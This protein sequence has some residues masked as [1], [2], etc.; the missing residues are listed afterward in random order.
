MSHRL[1]LRADW[2]RDPIG[3]CAE[4]SLRA[5]TGSFVRDFE[6]EP[7]QIFSPSE[8]VGANAGD[9]Y[10]EH[11]GKWLVM[12]AH[13]YRRRGDDALLAQIRSVLE[14]LRDSQ[15]ESGYLGT[16]AADS[17]ARFTHSDVGS[18]RTW[19]IWTHS[20]MMLGLLAAS[21]IPSLSEFSSV[22]VRLGNLL[23]DTFGDG[24]R[25][26]VEQGNHNGLSSAII[27]EPLVRLSKLTGDERYRD[28]AR[29]VISQLEDRGIP[30]LSGAKSGLDVSA[31]GTG[32]I[33]QLLWLFC[34][35]FDLGG[36]YRAATT[37][38]WTQI[39]ESH[40]NPLGG[41]W[42]GI[43]GHKEVFN[44]AGFFDPAG[45]VETC[46]TATWMALS[47]RLFMETGDAKY[48]EAVE[49]SL[50]NCLVGALDEN[51]AD[52]C[53]FTFP[54]G[55]R[56]NTY[57]WAC[58]KSSGALALEHAVDS[59]ITLSE[60]WVS[61]NQFVSS[62]AE[63]EEVEVSQQWDWCGQDLLGII[64]S[65][66]KTC[67]LRI[68][69]PHWATEVL[70]NLELN[71]ESGDWIELN[72]PGRK[73]EIC[74]RCEPIVHPYT[75][76]IDH[77]GQEIVREEYAYIT[78]GPLVYACGRFDGFREDETLRLARL[79]P[80]THLS[81]AGQGTFGPTLHLKLPGR[82]PIEFRPYAEAGGRHDHVWRRAYLQVAWQ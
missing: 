26:I 43:A 2:N 59:A 72:N 18:V 32:K 71:Q 78:L 3:D 27:I 10:G 62:W 40:L 47:Q 65:D 61:I 48:A 66:S 42:G 54:N 4:A 12:A 13:G 44:A 34:G 38:W 58:C 15:E 9:W 73:T 30:V 37:E 74:F 24:T 31:L 28:L 19:D 50:T 70:I 8:R 29:L 53:Y 36:E 25:S 79:N 41:P 14:F 81:L 82:Q 68:R 60:S 23:V 75:Y 51:G 64:Q 35:M 22:A 6:S 5:R 55:R 45:M 1:P 33:Y 57:H 11:A 39:S 63:F 17:S 67:G 20:W 76:T 56:N 46:S 52:W 69:R 16:Y 21:E 7:V 80:A 49:R 77:H